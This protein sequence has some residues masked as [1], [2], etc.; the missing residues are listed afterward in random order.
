MTRKSSS[1]TGKEDK[2]GDRGGY[3]EPQEAGTCPD[4]LNGVGAG[5]RGPRKTLN[6]RK[7]QSQEEAGASCARGKAG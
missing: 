6:A 7:G 2:M 4:S 3:G 5:N 1:P